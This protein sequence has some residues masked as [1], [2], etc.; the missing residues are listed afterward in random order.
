MLP[1]S[2]LENRGI[3]VK[4]MDRAEW[5]DLR[6]LELP[7]TA[8][9]AAELAATALDL[10]RAHSIAPADSWYVACA[11]HAQAQLWLSHA[12]E[13]GLAEKAQAAGAEVHLLTAEQFR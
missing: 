9:P 7:I 11:I 10:V 3:G 2:E 13:D 5:S 12:H 8:T 6:F 4:P 1:Q